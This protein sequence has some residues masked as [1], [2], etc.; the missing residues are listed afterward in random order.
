MLVVKKLLRQQAMTQAELSRATGIHNQDISRIV[1]GRIPPYPGHAKRI[2]KA[3]N[4]QG[5]PQ[6]LFI[7]ADKE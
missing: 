2:A 5:D 4:W 6:E 3:L 7:E 1:N